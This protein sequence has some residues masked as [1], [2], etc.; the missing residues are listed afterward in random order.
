[1]PRIDKSSHRD[2]QAV[3]LAEANGGQIVVESEE[4]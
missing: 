4:G 1:M 2:P 3:P